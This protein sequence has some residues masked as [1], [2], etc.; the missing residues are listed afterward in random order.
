MSTKDRSVFLC[1]YRFVT[2]VIIVIFCILAFV[3][4]LIGVLTVTIFTRDHVQF[5]YS[6]VANVN[7]VLL[8]LS[9]GVNEIV[10][11][12]VCESLYCTISIFKGIIWS[13]SAVCPVLQASPTPHM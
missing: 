13:L 1:I 8:A 6:A 7:Q 3:S 12:S 5:S 4:L 2:H 11:T 10:H 9:Y